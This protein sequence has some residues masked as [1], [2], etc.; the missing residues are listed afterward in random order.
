MLGEPWEKWMGE[1]MFSLPAL[2]KTMF[3]IHSPS[4]LFNAPQTG[5]LKEKQT[6]MTLF[7]NFI[8]YNFF[9]I[10]IKLFHT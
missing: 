10:K 6:F 3:P 2:K 1:A 9:P 8:L 4:C 5:A 7:S